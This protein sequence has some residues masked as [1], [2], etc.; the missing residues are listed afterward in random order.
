MSEIE[1]KGAT[2]ATKEAAR[3]FASGNDA[4][5][6]RRRRAGEEE[7]QAQSQIDNM[8][9]VEETLPN[10]SWASHGKLFLFL[11]SVYTLVLISFFTSLVVEEPA[12]GFT[13][14]TQVSV[15]SPITPPNSPRRKPSRAQISARR[16]PSA[17][18]YRSGDSSEALGSDYSSGEEQH[19]RHQVVLK[20]P[21]PKARGIFT[22][23]V[24]NLL[25]PS[26]AT[27]RS[28]RRPRSSL[29]SGHRINTT[30]SNSSLNSAFGSSFSLNSKPNSSRP[31][32]SQAR[33]RKASMDSSSSSAGSGS[34]QP[35]TPTD[36]DHFPRT[37]PP[38]LA[39]IGISDDYYLPNSNHM[40]FLDHG[41]R[42]GGHHLK[43][44]AMKM[45]IST[46]G[47]QSKATFTA[48]Y[49]LFTDWTTEGVKSQDE[50]MSC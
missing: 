41:D 14:P 38:S 19:R 33:R 7:A 35:A 44:E 1:L 15:A 18:S 46:E 23:D 21:P 24:S 4:Q 27:P 47:G 42:F 2:R 30:A 43:D 28:L 12:A 36:P 49:P 29:T 48:Y 37:S 16:S 50:P 11:L 31:S 10:T 25:P 26:P 9:D 17:E 45:N 3:A 34:S 8:V 39:G 6:E 32:H 20:T 40:Q 22:R 13:T 5:A